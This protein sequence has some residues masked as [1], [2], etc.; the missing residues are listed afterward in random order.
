[1][2]REPLAAAGSQIV[3]TDAVAAGGRMDKT[4]SSRVDGDMADPAALREKH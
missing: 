2:I 4:T 1:M 3:V